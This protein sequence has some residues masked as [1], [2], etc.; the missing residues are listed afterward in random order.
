MSV[1]SSLL[2]RRSARTEFRCCDTAFVVSVAGVGAARAADRAEQTARQLEAQL[3]AFDP[4]SAV[5]R[6]NRTGRVENPHVAAA[7]DRGLEYRD[8]TNGA[9][10]VRRGE[11]EHAIKAYL[12]GAADGVEA[13]P[14]GGA[15]AVDGDAVTATAPVDLNGLAKGY[16]VDRAAEA[17]A[18]VGRAGFVDGGG[19]IAHPTGPVA[20][21]SPYGDAGPVAVL[22]TEWDVATSGGYRRRRG[23]VDHVYDPRDGR[24]GAV[25]DLVTVVARRDCTEADAL[26]TT[27]AALPTEA[28][29]DLAAGWDG[30]EALLLAD[31]VFHRT[32][33]FR[34]HETQRRGG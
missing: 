9:F 22:D 25:A 13:T 31:G 26:A 20:I 2:G 16:V 6:L 1:V 14:G 5:S 28:A 4:D 17:L 10:D 30:L 11:F 18:G 19:D 21:E 32:E 27:L 12:R 15:V 7:V 8:R 3:D 29:L 23:E 33:G 34:D 24:V